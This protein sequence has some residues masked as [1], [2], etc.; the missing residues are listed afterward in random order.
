LTARAG[1]DELLGVNAP[2]PA[3]A[4]PAKQRSGCLVALLVLVGLF[5]LA[6]VAGGIGLVVFLRSDTGKKVAGAVGDGFKMTMAARNAPG[7]R[8]IEAAGCSDGMVLDVKQSWTLMQSIAG[9]G[10]AE[11]P[12]F[13]FRTVV[14][15]SVNMLHTPPPCEVVKQ[16]YLGAVPKP[17]E[18]FLVQV[19]AV[20]ETRARCRMVYETDG[21]FMRDLSDAGVR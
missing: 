7:A 6:C 13:L 1:P 3:P 11:Q 10:G 4:T 12:E 9:D 14:N 19:N 5:A 17:A 2:P 15:C 16:A 18:P 8:A 21:T 20:G